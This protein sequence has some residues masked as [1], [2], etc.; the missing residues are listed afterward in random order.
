VTI[1]AGEA[2]AQ[3]HPEPAQAGAPG[4][5]WADR[6]R[7]GRL[8]NA[9]NRLAGKP[10]ALDRATSAFLATV[11][12]ELRTPLTS[13]AGN[14]EMLRDQDAGP[15]TP[16]QAKMLA[17]VDRNTARLWRLIE[18]VLTVSKIESGAFRTAM[19][20]VSV[21]DVVTSVVAALQPEAAS[22]GLALTAGCAGGTM[23]VRGDRGQLGRLLGNLLSNAL[24]FT[25][26]GGRVEVTA[27]T[28]GAMAVLTV[29]DTG[30]GIPAAD[31]DRLFG[32]FFRASNAVDQSIPGAGMG[33]VIARTIVANHGGELD[34]QSA[35]RAG[36]TVT[37]RIPLLAPATRAG[38]AAPQVP[39][40]R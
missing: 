10:E 27:G 13:I 35:L 30:I 7:R 39:R 4:R 2:V 16:A 20:P 29:R 15:L 5:G 12:H 14:V 31:R 3:D 36:T 25:P 33:L 6:H 19:Q 40:A 23:T 28:D 1:A 26:R 9:A 21:A 37:V 22:R 24:K 8:S 11:S 17:T 32:R 34:L 38:R 18:D